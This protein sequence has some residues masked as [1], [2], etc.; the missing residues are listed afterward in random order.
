MAKQNPDLLI[1]N[2]DKI[3]S[4]ASKVVRESEDDFAEL[5][6][7]MK[8]EISAKVGYD[9][10]EDPEAEAYVDEMLAKLMDGV[11]LKEVEK[12]R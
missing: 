3:K 7:L 2:P 6:D 1:L 4:E 8:A 12:G 9:V 11:K 10:A 5:F